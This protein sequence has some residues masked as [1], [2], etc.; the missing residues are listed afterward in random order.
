MPACCA[1]AGGESATLPASASTGPTSSSG[2][3]S[4]PSRQPV[5]A[6]YFENE[7]TTTAPWP[8]NVAA[9]ACATSSEYAMPW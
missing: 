5:I 1:S 7:F 8:T 4:Q 9:V 6:Q 3:T 2:S